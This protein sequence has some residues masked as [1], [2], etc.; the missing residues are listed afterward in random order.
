MGQSHRQPDIWTKTIKFYSGS[1]DKPKVL[2]LALTGLASINID[3]TTINSGL[4]IPPFVD[5]YTLQKFSD[6]EQAR[7]HNLYCEVFVS[8]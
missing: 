5:H 4:S 1:P 7:L 6:S 3:E 2:I 8:Y